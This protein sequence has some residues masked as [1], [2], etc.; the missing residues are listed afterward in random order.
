MPRRL[1]V[2]I[3]DIIRDKAYNFAQGMDGS[4]GSPGALAEAALPQP[5]GTLV[6]EQAQ[7]VAHDAIGRE[8]L[9]YPALQVGEHRLEHLPSGA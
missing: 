3:Q 7:Q 1:W 2:G 5:G 8:P 9:G 6:R 4:L